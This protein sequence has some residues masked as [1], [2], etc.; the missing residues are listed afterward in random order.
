MKKVRFTA[1]LQQVAEEEDPSFAKLEDLVL[2]P[3]LS[4][5]NWQRAMVALCTSLTRSQHGLEH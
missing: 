1:N 2:D 3:P 5:G 4:S